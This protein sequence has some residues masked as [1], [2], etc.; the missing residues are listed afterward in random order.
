MR[1]LSCKICFCIWNYRMVKGVVEVVR[2]NKQ[3]GSQL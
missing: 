2:T 1:V 3:S